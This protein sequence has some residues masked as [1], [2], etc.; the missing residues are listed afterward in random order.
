[1]MLSTF[2]KESRLKQRALKVLISPTEQEIQF[3]DAQFFAVRFVYNKSLAIHKYFFKY[4]NLK[5]K[6]NKDIKPL[7][8]LK[9][10]ENTLG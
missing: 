5:L 4:H 6:I 9:K 3:I 7:P 1:M 8:L 10:Y 2:L